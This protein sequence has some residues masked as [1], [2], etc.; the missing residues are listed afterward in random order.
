MALPQSQ[1]RS[2]L[3]YLIHAVC[4]LMITTSARLGKN[5]TWHLGAYLAGACQGH[6]GW[7]RPLSCL[8]RLSDAKEAFTLS[9]ARK[10]AWSGLN[11]QCH[12]DHL[13]QLASFSGATCT[14]A[15]VWHKAF[16]VDPPS[17]L[18]IS[19]ACDVA[20]LLNRHPGGYEQIRLEVSG[21]DLHC[22]YFCCKC[23]LFTC[24]AHP[25]AGY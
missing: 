3:I 4:R 20:V 16:H 12:G 9:S 18:N 25:F 15:P 22:P 23:A 13:E 6:V 21:A 1:M 19:A 17:T 10:T 14:A 11:Q 24:H 2:E 5:K 7:A 8:Q